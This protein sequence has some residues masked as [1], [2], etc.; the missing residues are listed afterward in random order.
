MR[1]VQPGIEWQTTYNPF[2][3]AVGRALYVS[4][5]GVQDASQ[6]AY[7][8]LRLLSPGAASVCDAFPALG[9]GP[10]GFDAHVALAKNADPLEWTLPAEY[11]STTFVINVRPHQSGLELDTISGAQM[12]LSDAGGP[13]TLV[14]GFV[15]V[16]S[17]TKLDGGGL[18]VWF[19]FYTTFEGPQPTTFEIRD[20]AEV[21]TIATVSVNAVTPHNYYAEL[22]GLEDGTP[23]TFA[24]VALVDAAETD[25]TTFD[26]TGDNDGP[27]VDL[28]LTA[29]VW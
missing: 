18:R 13:G 22:S 2:D 21:P 5:A 7:R 17:T 27:D 12:V 29:E 16:L 6:I 14:F 24:I 10:L 11:L 28:T 19:R 26:V 3:G 8:N 20:N 9:D 4:P 1:I 25:M 15:E 23:Y